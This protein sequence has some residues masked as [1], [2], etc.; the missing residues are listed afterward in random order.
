VN[1]LVAELVERLNLLWD[2][3]EVHPQRPELLSCSSGSLAISITWIHDGRL[4]RSTMR[5]QDARTHVVL[6][7]VEITEFP[8]TSPRIRLTELWPE[9]VSA[10]REEL[11]E[12]IRALN[13]FYPGG[14]LQSMRNEAIPPYGELDDVSDNVTQVVRLLG[15]LGLP[16]DYPLSRMALHEQGGNSLNDGVRDL[17]SVLVSRAALLE[18]Y[19]E[20]AKPI[21]KNL[22]RTL[23]A[24]CTNVS[25]RPYQTKRVPVLAGRYHQLRVEVQCGHDFGD[26]IWVRVLENAGD[27]A[28]MILEIDYVWDFE[29][30]LLIPRL[31]TEILRRHVPTMQRFMQAIETIYPKGVMATMLS[32]ESPTNDLGPDREEWLTA[33]VQNLLYWLGN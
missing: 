14:M 17:V 2:G 18:T 28:F 33:N 21:L 30:R 19:D 11:L 5:L 1:L 8:D 22:V 16:S 20:A 29:P 4:I 7:G 12:V 31:D 10:H 6:F 3:V 24:H 26:A 23:V 27:Q 9:R 15:A 13:S 32:Y 25:L